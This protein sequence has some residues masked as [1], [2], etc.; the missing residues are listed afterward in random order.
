MYENE[1][2]EWSKDWSFLG[3]QEQYR[4]NNIMNEERIYKVPS[5]TVIQYNVAA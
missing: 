5:E 1:P 4:D 3:P 2:R